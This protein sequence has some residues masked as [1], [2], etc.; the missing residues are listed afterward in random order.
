MLRWAV[1]GGVVAVVCGP[2]S[3]RKV[4]LSRKAQSF[5][6]VGEQ[7]F[8]YIVS[9]TIAMAALAPP[10][11][12]SAP[13]SEKNEQSS[14]LQGNSSVCDCVIPS[15]LQTKRLTVRL[16]LW[17][18]TGPQETGLGPTVVNSLQRILTL[19]LR[20]RGFRQVTR[21]RRRREWRDRGLRSP[22]Q[23]QLPVCG[24]F[25]SCAAMLAK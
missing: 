2:S 11:R 8:G 20:L 15:V 18:L 10:H 1:G 24:C 12:L 3:T 22:D 4:S 21:R 5:S 6:E 16:S 14:C 25:A 9:K 17:L 19:L 7:C 23:A 13:P